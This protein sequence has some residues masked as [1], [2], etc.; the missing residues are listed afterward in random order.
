M[1]S[2]ANV[3]NLIDRVASNE[4]TNGE[5]AR[6]ESVAA[7]H[8]RHWEQLARALRDELHMRAALADALEISSPL[9]ISR[10]YSKQQRSSGALRSRTW[11]G[12][13]AAAM[14]ALAWAATFS[15]PSDSA[16]P[17]RQGGPGASGHAQLVAL[18]SDE[19][20]DQ[21]LRTGEREGRVIAE[22]PTLFVESH[23]TEDGRLEIFYVRQL[24]ERD[25]IAHVYE[26]AEDEHGSYVPVSVNPAAFSAPSSM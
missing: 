18:S 7:N 13:A 16:E 2:Q 8:P 14:I 23:P 1:M 26:L 5:F 19:A 21:Y 20:F 25:E 10:A 4:E 11:L 3:N 15:M 9:E 22:L 12:W 6:F 17:A 24:L